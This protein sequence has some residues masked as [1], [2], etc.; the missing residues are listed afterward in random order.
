MFRIE[1]L[2]LLLFSL[3]VLFVAIIYW[4]RR[5]RRPEWLREAAAVLGGTVKGT[6]RVEGITAGLPWTAA[7]SLG[8]GNQTP[9]SWHLTFPTVT[10]TDFVVRAE[11]KQDAR[12]KR[13]GFIEELSVGEAAFD[14]RHL[15]LCA[16]REEAGA[17]LRHAPL[18]AALS[19]L[20]LGEPRQPE[21]R[22]LW[23][24]AGQ[25][26][27]VELDVSA[28]A[29]PAC[30]PRLAQLLGQVVALAQVLREA[31]QR[32]TPGL[33]RPRLLDAHAEWR[34]VFLVLWCLGPVGLSSIG[35]LEVW[36][37]ALKVPF[38]FWTSAALG[39]CAAGVLL[40]LY[41][42][43]LR[44]SPLLHRRLQRIPILLGAG[45][46]AGPL[47]SLGLNALAAVPLES[48]EVEVVRSYPQHVG[49]LEF[50]QLELG[51]LGRVRLPYDK[52][53]PLRKQDILRVELV[54]G[55]LGFPRARSVELVR[56]GAQAHPAP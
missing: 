26:L 37:G 45:F 50:W 24:Q 2:Q 47:V 19:A 11:T 36:T 41:L 55:A 7:L 23:V 21:G 27:E 40:A 39:L 15:V 30:H 17:L 28:V 52:G 22:I 31:P 34:W 44:R 29:E 46:L 25:G 43:R 18:R 13:R 53:E 14:E 33:W 38:G 51:E 3:P 12:W 20:P 5:G 56:R 35:L 6:R 32:G 1:W 42:L 48:R 8:V 10:S 4:Q 16:R 49:A 9:P 54:R